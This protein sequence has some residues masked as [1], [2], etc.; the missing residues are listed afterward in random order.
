MDMLGVININISVEA[1]L[2][3]IVLSIDAFAASFAYG[4]SKIK[5]PLKSIMI[6]NII[7][8]LVLALSL[9]LGIFFRPFVPGEVADALSFGILF[10]LGLF[11]I[12]DSTVKSFI[13]KYSDTAKKVEFAAF[14]LKFILTVYA[15]PERADIDSSRIISSKE[16]IAIA[17]ALALDSFAV[18]FGAGLANVNH[19]QIIIFSLFT[20]VIAI[21]LGC[22][23][24]NKIAEKSPVN[25]S[26]LGGVILILLAVL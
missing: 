21:I 4:S 18:G 26:W 5:I 20:D 10:S 17:I 15:N 23:L 19:F 3:T 14:D 24:G 2:L 1:L 8:S 13:R 11:K 16:A 25:L 22:R 6:I 7:G 9:Y 12:F